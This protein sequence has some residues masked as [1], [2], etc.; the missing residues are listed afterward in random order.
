MAAEAEVEACP[1]RFCDGQ[2]GYLSC[3]IPE[4]LMVQVPEL[5]TA[6]VGES[7][8]RTQATRS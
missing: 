7:P 8:I 5:K 3:Q 6:G 2:K 4:A 1:F